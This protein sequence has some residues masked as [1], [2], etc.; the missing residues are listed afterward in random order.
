MRHHSLIHLVP[1]NRWGGP[2]RYAFDICSHF[3]RLGWRVMALTRDA[4]A[5]DSL[6][7][8][9]G[10]GLFHAPLRGWAD[11]ET[12]FT[13]AS[14][15]RRAPGL[16]VVHAHRLR[17][18][19]SAILARWLSRRRDTRV[20]L[21]LHNAR[22][23]RN[24]IFLRL[25]CRRIDAMV[26]DSHFS[27][28]R[29]SAPWRDSHMPLA[30]EKIHVLH[31]SLRLPGHIVPPPLQRRPVT[32]MFH[33][34]IAPGKGLET[35]IDSMTLMRGS[36][37]RLRIV[38]SGQPDYVDALR[39]RA[40]THGVME[41]IDWHRQVADPHPLI[42]DCHFGV[43][44]SEQEESFGLANVEYMANARA[45]VSTLC[46]ARGEYLH[47]GREII[48]VPAANA[49]ALAEAMTRLTR[50]PELRDAMGRE[51]RLSFERM[52]SWNSFAAAI[53]EVYIGPTR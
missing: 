51:A 15:L 52:L 41:M 9:D 28:S 30:K 23:P 42:A 45:Q 14:E 19:A 21:S 46:G 48:A 16:P 2:Q 6:F 36:G 7:K 25:L 37:L 1:S 11:M 29:F 49:S 53:E 22:R 33:G 12:A 43:L 40:I 24:S 10:I 3:S 35:L 32:A 38:G 20:V 34:P 4:R 31:N 26:F 5:I 44:P 47:D 17:D 18:A 8:A 27:L 50:Y 39:R 13:L